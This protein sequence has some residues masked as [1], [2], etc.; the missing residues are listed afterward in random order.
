MTKDPLT[1]APDTPVLE[2]INLLRNKGFRRL[3]VVKGGKLV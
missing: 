2:A 3:P 1:V